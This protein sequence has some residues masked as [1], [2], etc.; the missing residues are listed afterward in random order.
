MDA[1]PWAC[2][3]FLLLMFFLLQNTL[4]FTPG[5]RIQ[6]P[7]A[8]GFADISNPAVVVMM[9]LDG[10]FYFDRQLISEERL[11]SRLQDLVKA[12]KRPLALKVQADKGIPLQEFARLSLL[13]H[14]AGIRTLLLLTRPMAQSEIDLP[15]KVEP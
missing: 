4:F 5:I 9:D 13:A 15:D 14:Q 8:N 7:E 12:S 1:A 2:L 6:L 3:F 10:Q 11:L